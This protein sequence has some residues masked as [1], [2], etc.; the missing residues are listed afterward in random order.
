MERI[1][2]QKYLINEDDPNGRKFE[3][4]S[5]WYAGSQLD[6]LRFYLFRHSKFGKDAVFSYDQFKKTYDNELANELG[7]L[8]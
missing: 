2:L 3:T 6:A 4:Q 8:V 7:N 5:E 1:D